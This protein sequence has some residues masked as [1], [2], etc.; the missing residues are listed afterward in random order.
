MFQPTSSQASSSSEE[1]NFKL[2]L[3]KRKAEQDKNPKCRVVIKVNTRINTIYSIEFE[4]M[5]LLIMK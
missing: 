2:I 5:L 1:S 3:Q 4:I